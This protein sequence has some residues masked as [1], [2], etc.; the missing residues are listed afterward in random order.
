[1]R[2]ATRARAA[3]LSAVSVLLAWP[4]ACSSADDPP[5]SAFDAAGGS[6]GTIAGASGAAGSA[7]SSG[8]AAG[9]GGLILDAL[10]EQADPDAAC[11]LLTQE[12]S[13]T[14]LNLYIMMDKSSSLAGYKWDAAVAGL[15]AFVN[16]TSSAGIRVALK[17]FP[18]EPDG[19]PACDQPAYAVPDVAF[20]E[21]PANAAAIVAALQAQTP[22]GLGTPTYPALGGAI[23][24][25]IEVAQNAPGETS[26]VLLVTDGVPQGPAPTCAGVDP[27]AT[28]VLADLAATGAGYSP[29]VLT[30][31]IGL[32][33]VDQSFADAIASGGGTD[34]AIVVGNTNV[35]VEFEQ[36]LAQVRGQALPCEFE[37]PDAVAGGQV[38]FDRVNVLFTPGGSSTPETIPQT[39]DCNQASGWY[40]DDPQDP[41]RILLCPDECDKLK[42]DYTARLDILLGCETQTVK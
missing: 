28:Q 19:T 1:M 14:P 36:A 22:N 38:A 4:L 40:Y 24:K 29:P 11:G 39:S 31:V 17:F 12:A 2:H 20:G 9:T 5:E 37:I 34:S 32:P 8:G 41:A 7:G 30:F 13:A 26:A 6:G 33:G 3:A 18:R 42:G 27:E 23:L 21:L 10:S 16:D 15:D 25:G 35:Q